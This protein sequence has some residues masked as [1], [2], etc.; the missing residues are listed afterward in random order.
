LLQV[1]TTMMTDLMWNAGNRNGTSRVAI[2]DI[3]HVDA[4]I[5][6]FEAAAGVQGEWELNDD[7]MMDWWGLTGTYKGATF[8]LY[9]HKSGSLKIGAHTYDEALDVNGLTAVLLAL[10]G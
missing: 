7:G 3:E 8:T 9:T 10:V 6:K 2:L 5:E 4:A 1:V